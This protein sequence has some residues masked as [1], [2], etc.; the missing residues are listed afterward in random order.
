MADFATRWSEQHETKDGSEPVM[1]GDAVCSAVHTAEPA[2]SYIVYS[3]F[4]AIV[5]L[6]LIPLAFISLLFYPYNSRLFL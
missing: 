3:R 2:Y 6:N 5:E 4:L 1:V